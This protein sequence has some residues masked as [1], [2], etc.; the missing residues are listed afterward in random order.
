MFVESKRVHIYRTPVGYV[1]KTWSVVLLNKKN[2]YSYLKCVVYDK[3]LKPRQ[4]FRITLCMFTH[5]AFS[6]VN[7][8]HIH[9][10]LLV[11]TLYRGAEKS[12][13]RP[14]RKQANVSVRMT[15]ISFGALPCRKKK[16]KTW[17]QF[18]SRCCWNRV[19]PWH[20]SELVFFMVELR[21]YQHPG[22]ADCG[23]SFLA[24]AVTLTQSGERPGL[25]AARPYSV[26]CVKAPGLLFPIAYR[27]PDR[28]HTTL[29]HLRFTKRNICPSSNV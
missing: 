12:L 4:S 14:G 23:F 10:H 6:T 27:G 9:G 2:I 5:Y 29:G 15:W 3:L 17:R 19:R 28:E 18:A 25:T 16:K 7:T 13:A 21:T 26:R 20:A 11:Q 8:T 22:T 24:S 1:T